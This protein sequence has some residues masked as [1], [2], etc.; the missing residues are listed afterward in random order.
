MFAES[1]Y[2][3]IA[4]IFPCISYFP[5]YFLL[6]IPH[7]CSTY[8]IGYSLSTYPITRTTTLCLDLRNYLVMFDQRLFRGSSR[9]PSIQLACYTQG[10]TQTRH[11]VS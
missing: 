4:H 8:R 3:A 2:F 6:R 11:L 7:H 1:K 10:W 5:T 9:V